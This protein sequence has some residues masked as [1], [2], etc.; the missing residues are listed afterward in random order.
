MRFGLPPLP[1]L[2]RSALGALRWFDTTRERCI[3]KRRRVSDMAREVPLRGAH[4]RTRVELRVTHEW[5]ATLSRATSVS[6]ARRQATLL[7]P[8][9]LR[10]LVSGLGMA[11]TGGGKR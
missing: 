5:L 8:S 11:V 3:L 2:A 1:L 9:L 7:T 6:H 4:G 10:L